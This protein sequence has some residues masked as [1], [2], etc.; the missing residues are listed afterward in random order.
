MLVGDRGR[1]RGFAEKSGDH[2]GGTRLGKDLVGVCVGEAR[3]Q[4]RGNQQPTGG[5][6]Q[7]MGNTAADQWMLD[8][9]VD[10]DQLT[11]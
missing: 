7:E 5:C 1:S 3:G 10:A 2:F 4:E 9:V 6:A 8:S 11:L